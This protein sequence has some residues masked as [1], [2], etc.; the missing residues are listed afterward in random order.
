M[1]AAIAFE[2]LTKS[3]VLVPPWTTLMNSTARKDSTMTFS[4]RSLTTMVCTGLL[5]AGALTT[6]TSSAASASSLDGP[7][8]R[9]GHR[10]TP[11]HGR[12]A[13]DLRADL[14]AYLSA[15][16]S[17]EHISAAGLSVRLP[18]QRGTVNIGT[19]T[20]RVGGSRAVRSNDVWQIG[21]NTKAF[22]SV[23]LLQL[24]AEHRLSI[25]DTLGRWLPRYRQW[26]GVTIKSLLNMTSG[27]P[28]YDD[29][30]AF[31]RA[32]AAQPHHYFSS[33]Q[34]V[35][36]AASGKATHGYSYSNTNY[37]LG[38]MI[39]RKVTHSSYRSELRRRI[40]RPVHLHQL[41]Y[42][43]AHYPASVTRREPAGYFFNKAIPGLARLLGHDVSR[44]TLS[45]AR[46]A[47]GIV[48]TTH[49]MTVWEQALYHGRVLPPQQQREL[50]SL[51]SAATGRPIRRTTRQDP[52]GFGLGIAQLT[53][54]G[55]G[56]FWFYEGATLGF[57]TVHIYLPRS[58][59]IFAVAVNSQS[60]VDN[61]SDLIVSV[62]GT[63][64]SHGVI[65]PKPS[66]TVRLA[67]TH[68]LVVER[69]AIS[70]ISSS[71]LTE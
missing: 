55:I 41:Y 6:A 65:N 63:L 71:L 27:I 68:G 28:T 58:G 33:R 39:I 40:I 60:T 42:Q 66:R 67:L 69:R 10:V 51:V 7:H 8:A 19:G 57:R 37:V 15:H 22:T 12:L 48:S 13:T 3:S 70:G 1:S 2:G 34:L 53:I 30:P 26:R 44:T 54:P 9:T 29:S 61:I 35:A 20:M 32:F 56:R 49:A 43:T 59:V 23:I 24:E 17:D 14:V 62:Q 21:S 46:G 16:N 47:G 18:G 4:S 36:F 5:T 38:E 52:Q 45:W 31:L 11:D 25:N 64:V 50:R